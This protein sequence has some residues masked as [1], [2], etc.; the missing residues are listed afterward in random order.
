MRE[1]K[2][3]IDNNMHEKL[4]DEAE[5]NHCFISE[6][7][8]NIL[9]SWFNGCKKSITVKKRTIEGTFIN[10]RKLKKRLDNMKTIQNKFNNYAMQIIVRM[11]E[12]NVPGKETLKDIK[13][14]VDSINDRLNSMDEIDEDYKHLLSLK[15]HFDKSNFD[16]IKQII[17]YKSMKWKYIINGKIIPNKFEIQILEERL[18]E[19]NKEKLVMSEKKG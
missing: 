19:K 4:K 7:V 3:R 2:A 12:H 1:I 14:L 13:L 16:T 15:K 9:S 11:E 8:R 10:E 5:K 6:L 17:N 18:Q